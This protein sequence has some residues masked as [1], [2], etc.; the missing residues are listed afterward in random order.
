MTAT[1]KKPAG[2]KR[3]RRLLV[4][5]GD[6]L[7]IE[8]KLLREAD[9][10]K[11]LVWMAE[12]KGEAGHVWSTKM[13]I[14]VFFA[15]M[16][17]FRDHLKEEGWNVLYQ[18]V[19]PKNESLFDILSRDLKKLQPEEVA[20]TLP[21]E[22]RIKAGL[23]ECCEQ[24]GVPLEIYP[25]EHFL[26]TPESFAEWAEGRKQVRLEFYYREMRKH[27][28]VLMTK[29]GKPAGGDWNF[30]KENRGSFGKEGPDPLR[31]Q[32]P[33]FAPDAITKKVLADVEKH[34]RDHPGGLASFRWPVTR[35]QALEALER[36]CEDRLASFGEFQD[37]MWTEEPFL[38]H[39]LL[40]SSLNTKLLRPLE[41]VRRA[42]KAY[43]E[44]KAPLAAVEGF[45]RQ[46]LGW[47]EYVR[48]IY[49]WKM[50]AYVEGNALEAEE[51]LPDF[52]WTGDTPLRCLREA[53]GQ[54][55][56]HGYAHHIQRLMVTGLYG[57]LL[58]VRPQE[59]HAWYLAVYVDAVEWVELPNTLGM[60]QFGDGGLMAS[61][62][63]AATGKYIQRMS[64]YCRN[65]PANPGEATG[66]KACP[67]T[68][69][70]WD[71]LLRNKERLADNQRMK[72][73]LRNTDRLSAQ[74]IEAIKERAAAV[75]KD[76]AG[77][78]LFP[79]GEAR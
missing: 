75:R 36:F 52:Y 26:D 6:Q 30:D 56:E 59:V 9:P 10:K 13:R 45:V 34:F 20:V 77:V 22:W 41:V 28:D 66:E 70:Y 18:E 8:A 79:Q 27:H 5:F 73:Q 69:L 24:A 48:G 67:F 31:P 40:S 23:E 33:E 64:N 62:P 76:P 16:R 47:R 46:I 58:G 44:K 72:L 37:A 17:H 12:A 55:L 35:E 39:A 60:S 7:D 2:A 1:K 14:A 38:Y 51:P 50:P 19:G 63:Y 49:W 29:Q 4:L 74:R 11:D 78:G 15:A 42:E 71:F 25:D 53:V 32:P 57:L 61:K 54:T 68:T 3:P 43:E 65:C 21:G